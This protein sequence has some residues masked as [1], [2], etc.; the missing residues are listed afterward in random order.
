MSKPSALLKLT[1][2]LSKKG[3]FLNELNSE[4]KRLCLEERKGK[5]YQIQDATG[6]VLCTYSSLTLI[7]KFIARK[8]LQNDYN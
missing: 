6:K 4:K 3:Y 2:E 7:R 5:I 8:E 1:H